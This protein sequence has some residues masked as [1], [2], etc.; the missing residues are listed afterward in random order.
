LTNYAEGGNISSV[1]QFVDRPMT[2][3]AHQQISLH[4]SR[5]AARNGRIGDE[6]LE[7]I[8]RL[9]QEDCLAFP[10]SPPA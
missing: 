10:V 1:L 6:A 9:Y 8:G 5:N 2:V 3:A 4:K 7:L